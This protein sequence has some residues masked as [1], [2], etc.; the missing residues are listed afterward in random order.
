MLVFLETF[1][2]SLCVRLKLSSNKLA[3]YNLHILNTETLQKSNRDE[4]GDQHYKCIVH[5]IKGSVIN[6]VI[7]GRGGGTLGSDLNFWQKLLP[8]SA[9]SCLIYKDKIQK[10]RMKKKQK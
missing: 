6:Y 2:V 4:E 8:H 7:Q 10:C 1:S 3:Q 5:F 9:P